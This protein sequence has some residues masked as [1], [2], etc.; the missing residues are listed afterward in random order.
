M[1]EKELREEINSLNQIIESKQD[2]IN[3]L[4]GKIQKLR[5]DKEAITRLLY[6]EWK[7]KFELPF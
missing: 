1:K 3:N 2:A 7:S 6:F 5:A 4:H